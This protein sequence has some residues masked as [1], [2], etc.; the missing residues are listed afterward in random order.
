[1]QNI[2]I[3]GCFGFIGSSLSSFLC[4][5]GATVS[6][7]GRGQ[8]SSSNLE[9]RFI[10]S[11]LTSTALDRLLLE[12]GKPDTLYHCVGSGSVGQAQLNPKEDFD[13]S[14][15]SLNNLLDWIRLY[16]PL[17]RVII[18]SSAAVYGA[19]YAG[20]ISEDDARSPF[21]IYGYH[22]SIS[23]VICESYITNYG[24][25]IVVTRLFS[26][27]GSGLKKQLLWDCCVKV[28]K[29][30]PEST[31][32]LFGTGREV[33][34]WIHI[35]DVVRTLH[36]LGLDK[37]KGLRILNVGTGRANTVRALIEHIL[38][39]WGGEKKS[40]TVKFNGKV[41]KGDPE[42]LISDNTNRRNL[43]HDSDLELKNGVE[44]FVQWFKK[45]EGL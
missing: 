30:E 40:I 37:P 45:N 15:V 22:K 44:Q 12:T 16:S 23:E 14:V 35:T 32:E 33:R 39:A 18:T 38:L 20:A 34:D 29:A 9:S 27:Y 11:N 36:I 3:T 1:M 19:E 26:V 7:I 17:T 10:C 43:V 41:R 8:I 25:D 28:S 42:S 2:W 21:S 4:E 6:G 31:I 24:L 5:K 13:S